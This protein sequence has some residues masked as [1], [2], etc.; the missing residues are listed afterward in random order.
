M[1]DNDKMKNAKLEVSLKLIF[2][3]RTAMLNKLNSILESDLAPE[4]K[5]QELSKLISR[6][7]EKL[8]NS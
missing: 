6:S 3:Q 2:L 7:E 5:F 8:E 4:E 1:P